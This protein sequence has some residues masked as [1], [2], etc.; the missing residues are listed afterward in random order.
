MTKKII[1]HIK[2]VATGSK[3]YVYQYTDG[4]MFYVTDGSRA[5]RYKERVESDPELNINAHDQS[6]TGLLKSRIH[7]AEGTILCKLPT[8]E[9]IKAGITEI[10]GRSYSV[11]VAYGEGRFTVNARYLLKAMDALNATVCYIH[12][13]NAHM[14]CIYLYK[15]DDLQSD[16]VELI[17][18]I[19]KKCPK[20]TGFW[21]VV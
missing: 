18:P 17:M 21:A 3:D 13:Y 8:K 16:I 14:K 19:N 6:I 15:D 12:E 10:A 5:I 4:E 11:V 2:E 1:S 7:L 20:Q 9:E